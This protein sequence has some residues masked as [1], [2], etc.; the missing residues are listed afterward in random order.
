VH[1]ISVF[2]VPCNF[3]K[4]YRI[5]ESTGPRESNRSTADTECDNGHSYVVATANHLH[6]QRTPSRD[7][8]S[9]STTANRPTCVISNGVNT[10]SRNAC[11]LSTEADR[12]ARVISNGVSTYTGTKAA[13]GAEGARTPLSACPPLRLS[14][15]TPRNLRGGRETLL[16]HS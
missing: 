13:R 14:Y 16:F 8:C 10:P 7:T 6:L 5:G 15:S 12:P 11:S 1:F 4:K 3:K 9:L 2:I